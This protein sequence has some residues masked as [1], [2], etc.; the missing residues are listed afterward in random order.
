MSGAVV[1]TFLH[2]LRP[3]R[4]RRFAPQRGERPVAQIVVECPEVPCAEVNVGQ[5]NLGRGRAVRSGR[6]AHVDRP[7]G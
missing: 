4:D 5:R 1:E 3:E 7:R 6:N 2:G